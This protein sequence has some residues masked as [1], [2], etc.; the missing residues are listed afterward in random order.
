M[1]STLLDGW[2]L[3][4]NMEII[5]VFHARPTCHTD[6]CLCKRT[7][8]EITW[9]K[10]KSL[11]VPSACELGEGFLKLAVVRAQSNS[12]FLYRNMCT[13]EGR[14]LCSDAQ[15]CSI[16]LRF[17]E[18]HRSYKT[19]PSCG[20]FSGSFFYSLKAYLFLQCPSPCRCSENTHTCWH[21][22]YPLAVFRSLCMVSP[23]RSP[24]LFNVVIDLITC[25]ILY[26]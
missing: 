6:E 21:L 5:Q 7:L 8:N 23:P 25:E 20:Q 11:K 26:M 1:L 13:C 19:C 4:P 18:S 10:I 16:L 9:G 17:S 22:L 15:L 2:Q 14:L 3:V 12:G 24:E